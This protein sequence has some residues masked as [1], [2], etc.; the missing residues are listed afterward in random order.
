MKTF[1]RPECRV[2]IRERLKL[3]RADSVRRWG[4]MT[5][6][7][8]VCHCADACR[9][10][11]GEVAPRDISTGASRSAIKWIALYAPMR[12]P[13]GIQTVDEF[14]Q[15][16]AGTPP[17]TFPADVAALEHL[18]DRIPA[19]GGARWPRHPIFGRMSERA[20]LRWAYLHIDHHLRQ[21]GV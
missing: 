18:L 8:M 17:T 6:H 4:T 19:G 3:L 20:W 10:A 11:L 5:A 21:F 13:T 2:E 15:R 1:A 14:D 9:M 12:W 7:Q 16:T